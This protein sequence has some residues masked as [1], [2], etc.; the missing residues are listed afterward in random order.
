MGIKRSD[1]Y[2][3]NRPESG[4]ADHDERSFDESVL[5]KEKQ[6]LASNEEEGGFIPESHENPAQARVKKSRSKKE[7][8]I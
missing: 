6:E 5:N 1:Q 2:A 7:K 4:G 8:K 3:S